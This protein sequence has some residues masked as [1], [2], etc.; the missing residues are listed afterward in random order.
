MSIY[1]VQY[2]GYLQL[3]TRGFPFA[4]GMSVTRRA[5]YLGTWLFAVVEAAVFG[6]VLLALRQV[7]VATDGWG[8]SLAYFGVDALR[9]DNPALQWLA[10]VVPFLLVASLGGCLGLVMMRWSY[11]GLLTVVAGLIV[12]AGLTVIVVTR[13]DWWG[14][15]GDWFADQSAAALFAGWPLPVAVGFALLGFAT[16]RRATL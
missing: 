15:I 4:L 1:V 14:A 5:Y 2:I 13:Q 3:F 6:T 8:M 16:I 11:N 12:A 9:S 10:Y 7:E